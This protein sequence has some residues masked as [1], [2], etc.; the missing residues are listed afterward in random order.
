MNQFSN[1]AYSSGVPGCQNVAAYSTRQSAALVALHSPFIGANL[2]ADNAA[3]TRRVDET[4]AVRDSVPSCRQRSCL[5]RSS[6]DV[7][8]P[9][10]D[11]LTSPGD[12][13]AQLP[14]PAAP[15]RNR[16]PRVAMYSSPLDRVAVRVDADDNDDDLVLQQHARSY[17]APAAST[18]R[19]HLVCTGDHSRSG[20]PRCSS[21]STQHVQSTSPGRKRTDAER[22]L[23]PSP[24][25]PPTSADP[26]TALD[27]RYRRS[28]PLLDIDARGTTDVA[29]A[30]SRQPNS[31]VSLP[32]I[33][34]SCDPLLTSRRRLRAARGRLNLYAADDRGF[35]ATLAG[36]A[37]VAAVAL[38]L[39]AVG[40]QLLFR[41]TAAELRS[42]ATTNVDDSL[43]PPAPSRTD[44]SDRTLARA[45]VEEV[46]IVLAAVTVAL[47][48]C[49]LLT[50]SMQCFFAVKLAR[51][52]NAEVRFCS[53]HNHLSS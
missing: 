36:M 24:P 19:H 49:C 26:Q 32:A 7:V 52:R 43:L 47:D 51:C 12:R 40:V 25:P 1:Y 5:D 18:H 27:A 44:G 53:V 31:A 28:Y 33:S 23:L 21:P 20:P 22:R 29:S 10:T 37:I 13:R 15:T 3:G 9:P 34:G 38:V 35:V 30:T 2:A 11:R 42:A 16:L 4:A 8:P 39:G 41:L 50:I 6:M 17:S 45:V 14:S 46:A 48:L